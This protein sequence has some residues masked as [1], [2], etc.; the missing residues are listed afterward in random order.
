MKQVPLG[1][2]DIL[3]SELCFGCWQA[4]GWSTSDDEHF[5]TM[6][7]RALDSGFTFFDT[8]EAYGNGHSEKLLGKALAGRREQVVLSSKF[9]FHKSDPARIRQSLESSLKNLGTDYID[10]YHQ[11][12]PPKSPPLEDTIRELEKLKA[13]GKIRAVGVSNWMEPE[14]AEIDD[15]SRIDCLQPCYSLLWRSIERTVLPLCRANSIAVI[16][17]SPLCQGILAGKFSDLSNVPADPRK[18]NRF[19]TPERWPAVVHVLDVLREVA[20]LQEKPLA[21]V[22]LRW[23]LDQPGVTAPIVGMTSNSQLEGNL[24]ALGWHLDEVSLRRLDEVSRAVSADLKP[25]DSLWNWHPR[26]K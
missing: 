22:A 14:W 7:H 26:E 16:P 25:H 9:P 5:I 4:H 1:K 12:W 18:D 17:Y 19:L 21:A 13:E 8:A 11:H 24:Q 3:V 20:T 6:V 10:L 23:L 15:A 2:T